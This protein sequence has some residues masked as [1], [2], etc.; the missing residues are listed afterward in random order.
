MRSAASFAGCQSESFAPRSTSSMAWRSNSNGTRSS[1]SAFTSR[2]PATIPSLGDEIVSR[3]PVPTAEKPAPAGPCM[4]TT[5]RPARWRLS[6]REVSCSICA[7]AASEMGA[8]SRCRLFMRDFSFKGTDTERTIVLVRRQRVFHR[9]FGG[10]RRNRR[11]VFAYIFQK[12][13][14]GHKKQVSSDGA[15]EVEQPIVITGRTPDEHVRKHLLNRT[16]RAAIANEIG[17]KF[18]HGRPPERHVVAQDFDLFPVFDDGS[19]RIV[20]GGWLDGI[21]QF[22]VRQ[23]GAADNAFLRLR[24]QRIPR[25][26]IM[27]IFLHDDVTAV[28]ERGVLLAD[29]HGVD[30]RFSPRIFSSIDKADEITVVEVTESLHLVYRRNSTADACHNLRRKL[31]A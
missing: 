8:S 26:K 20:R 12:R 29:E 3:C 14:G 15:T 11:L 31:E 28:S 27:K 16:G 7:H 18:T 22:D 19:E 24:R 23:L 6:V 21:V 13:R 17:T 25:G 5:R 1:T 2:C 9:W 10:C 4:S 30:R